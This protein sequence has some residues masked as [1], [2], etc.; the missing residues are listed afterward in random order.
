MW[1][2]GGW[3]LGV[4]VGVGEVAVPD[5]YARALRRMRAPAPQG[6]RMVVAKK[7]G[8]GRCKEVRS[9]RAQ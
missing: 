6:A 8:V 5:V 3:G 4:G 9:Y 7:L 2:G 1:G